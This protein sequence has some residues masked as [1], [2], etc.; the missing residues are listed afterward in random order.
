[1]TAY[2]DL[3][4][5][6]LTALQWSALGVTLGPYEGTANL[7]RALTFQAVSEVADDIL[8]ASVPTV[9]DNAPCVT[10]CGL[11][12]GT[13]T[14]TAE[15]DFE[16]LGDESVWLRVGVAFGASRFIELGRN[17]RVQIEGELTVEVN[18]TLEIGQGLANRLATALVPYFQDYRDGDLRFGQASVFRLA[19]VESGTRWTVRLTVP[20]RTVVASPSFAS[21]LTA[22]VA[23][24][25]PSFAFNTALDAIRTRWADQI[26]TLRF[27]STVYDNEGEQPD[28]A[29]LDTT[30]A[31]LSILPGSK[32]R[33][34]GGYTPTQRTPGIVQAS[35][36][37]AAE[38]GV[39]ALL[40]S[41]DAIYAA[42]V[43]ANIGGVRY[44]PLSL[45]TGVR[46]DSTWRVDVRIP[47]TFE[48]R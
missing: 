23:P 15:A 9:W 20:F 36:H 19:R 14:V 35:L 12:L 31:R 37:C 25:P 24:V 48:E 13:P 30:W 27:I 29:A 46:N 3:L 22:V 6:D 18:V 2:V 1:M 40:N 32:S 5:S 44:G 41:V 26:E 45:Q 21:D 11:V 43:G 7:A 28:S 34:E 38:I 39:G 10:Y 16:A 47:F 33:V 4:A 42:F 17:G 8:G